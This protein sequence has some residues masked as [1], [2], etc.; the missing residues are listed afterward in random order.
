[1]LDQMGWP[2]PR[3]HVARSRSILAIMREEVKVLNPSIDYVFFF[4]RLMQLVVVE[5]F[6]KAVETHDDETFKLESDVLCH[7]ENVYGLCDLVRSKLFGSKSSALGRF[8]DEFSAL[9]D[10]D[11][12][13]AEWQ[14]FRAAHRLP[15]VTFRRDMLRALWWIEDDVFGPTEI[16][17]SFPP[18]SDE[19]APSNVVISRN[20]LQQAFTG[21]SDDWYNLAEVAFKPVADEEL[22]NGGSDPEK[23]APS[24]RRRDSDV[25]V[26]ET[27]PGLEQEDR[28]WPNKWV[29]IKEANPEVLQRRTNIDLKDKY[30]NLVKSKRL[31]A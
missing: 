5:R 23:R 16:E 20:M 9:F 13:K 26:G 2:L 3:E 29:L 25:F 21:T 7:A 19:I 6:E 10:K 17:R 11:E 31:A 12:P 18:E 1:M 28:I 14:A 24:K 15:D 4:E 8:L 22:E 27:P 30:R